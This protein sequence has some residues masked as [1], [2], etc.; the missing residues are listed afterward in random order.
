MIVYDII[1]DIIK[2]HNIK[3]FNGI[4]IYF[5]IKRIGLSQFQLQNVTLI[6]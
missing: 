3:N 4:R 5:S 1:N 2:K 6:D